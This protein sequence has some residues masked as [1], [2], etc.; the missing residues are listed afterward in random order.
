MQ[1]TK[2][3]DQFLPCFLYF[4]DLCGSSWILT[5]ALMF[6]L[7]P[8]FSNLFS[9]W[10]LKTED[11]L[12]FFLLWKKLQMPLL[13]PVGL[14][15]TSSTGILW[16]VLSIGLSSSLAAESLC[17][18]DV[19]E[20]VPLLMLSQAALNFILVLLGNIKKLTPSTGPL[21][22]ANTRLEVI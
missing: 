5:S 2:A 10:S 8:V 19:H 21:G 15:W 22:R 11:G 17:I 13:F 18:W 7:F 6:C 12:C 16:V 3:A 20:C 1:I 9:F 14:S 4:E